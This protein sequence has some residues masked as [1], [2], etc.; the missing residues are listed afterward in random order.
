MN[1]GTTAVLHPATGLT[2]HGV[3]RL[4]YSVFFVLLA[5]MCADCYSFAGYKNSVG[6]VL[7]VPTEYRLGKKEKSCGI[8]PTSPAILLIRSIASTN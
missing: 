5:R 3:T 8:S 7:F 4:K 6:T 1:S 2:K